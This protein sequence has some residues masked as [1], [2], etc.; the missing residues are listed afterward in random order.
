MFMQSET[1]FIYHCVSIQYVDVRN[2]E[3]R[4]TKLKICV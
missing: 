4:E 1:P 2:G 3:P